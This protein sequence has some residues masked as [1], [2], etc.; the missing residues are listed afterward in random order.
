MSDHP[1]Q[2]RT[3]RLLFSIRARLTVLVLV[4]LAGLCTFVVARTTEA[5]AAAD[6]VTQL[7][8]EAACTLDLISFT[9]ALQRERFSLLGAA[10]A[11]DR[12]VDPFLI[13]LVA[14]V[15]LD[16]NIS[17]VQGMVDDVATALTSG[18]PHPTGD[19]PKIRAFVARIHEL[20][21][22]QALN[23]TSTSTTATHTTVDF[24]AGYDVLLTDVNVV[25]ERRIETLRS[26]LGSSP[27]ELRIRRAV[28]ATEAYLVY[29]DAL[30]ASVEG[31]GHR[32]FPIG[33]AQIT[34]EELA[35]LEAHER[36][37][38]DRLA[39][40]LTADLTDEWN[41]LT[42]AAIVA[43]AATARTEAL[44]IMAD[45]KPGEPELVPGVPLSL[46]RP[47]A[48]AVATGSARVTH[49]EGFT[50]ALAAEMRGGADQAVEAAHAEYR[51]TL[52]LTAAM[53]C[54][55][56]LLTVLT[57]R[58]IVGPLSRLRRHAQRIVEGELDGNGF[59]RRGPMEVCDVGEAIDDIVANL[60]QLSTQA[61][62]LAN[63]R[64]DAP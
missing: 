50:D 44:R 54:A 6:D 62:A 41:A 46:L 58:S 45:G 22:Q 3:S 37:A 47:G 25:L 21:A 5:R 55:T 7:Q 12:S 64:L 42:S 10:A 61:D 23:A 53:L 38:L 63:G 56:F 9:R 39:E 11:T 26:S 33:S 4:P 40:S 16:A 52:A 24:E 35:L 29:L 18:P 20:R 15:D 36:F 43:E 60:R 19:D 13:K 51:R 17:E 14:G 59:G 30:A 28:I 34:A 31:L 2:A 32:V 49:Y 57:L 1:H 48:K 8:A 27:P